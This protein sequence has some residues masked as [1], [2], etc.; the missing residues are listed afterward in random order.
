VSEPQAAPPPA[1]VE[2]PPAAPSAAELAAE[3]RRQAAELAAQ[4]RDAARRRAAQLAAKRRAAAA[5]RAK[6][7]PI[8]TLRAGGS[9]TPEPVTASPAAEES[10]VGTTVAIVLGVP[11]SLALVLLLLAALPAERAPWYWAEEQLTSRR[12]QFEVSGLMCVLVF[13]EGVV[14]AM[15]FVGG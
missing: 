10:S 13:A 6:S 14:F 9:V 15:V 1:A 8:R 7:R 2:P 12:W 11:G 4:R 3:A 5:A